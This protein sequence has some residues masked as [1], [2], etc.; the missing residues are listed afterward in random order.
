MSREHRP[1]DLLAAAQ[2]GLLPDHVPPADVAARLRATLLSRLSTASM[3]VTR[4][5]E[6]QWRAVLP[7][8]RIKRLRGGADDETETN[9]WR[10]DPGAVLPP[11]EH[12]LDEECLVQRHPRRH[13]LSRRRLPARVRRPAARPVPFA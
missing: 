6:G 5:D 3:R 11:H 2:A 12:R 9:L 1:E 4:A 8:V 10:L 7:G 13:R